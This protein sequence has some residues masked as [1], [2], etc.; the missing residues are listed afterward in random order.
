MNEVYILIKHLRQIA[1]LEEDKAFKQ[2]NGIY[3]TLLE[4]FN[5]AKQQD[6]SNFEAAQKL[7]EERIKKARLQK[8]KH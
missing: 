3:D 4:I 7:A 5:I 6:V 1:G 2:L 8:A